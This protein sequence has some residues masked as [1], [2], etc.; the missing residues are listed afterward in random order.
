MRKE[1][2]KG[3]GEEEGGRGVCGEEREQGSMPQ[4]IGNWTSLPVVE[5]QRHG[6]GFLKG[7]VQGLT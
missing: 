2:V 1:D 6:E 4:T 5:A 3:D 7:P